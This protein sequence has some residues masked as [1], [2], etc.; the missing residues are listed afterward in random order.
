MSNWKMLMVVAL[1]AS[2]ISFVAVHAQP[3]G[4]KAPAL[5]ALDYAEIE[6]LNAHY[7]NALDTCADKGNEFADLF[8]PDGVYVYGDGRKVQGREK[9]A[10]IAGGPDCA[11]PKNTP[12]NIHHV[13]VN[14]MIESSPDGIIGKS[15]FLAV[16]AGESGKPAQLLDGAKV[17][18]VYTKTS[19]GW[20]F[21]S[22]SYVHAPHTDLIPASEL[23]QHPFRR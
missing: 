14:T 13:F 8:A 12:L 20:R 6:Q 21:K 18:D 17:Y 7:A 1:A 5:T 22:R 10:A 4:A 23:S 3:K 9:L 15:Y 11:P 2:V 16:S 19:A